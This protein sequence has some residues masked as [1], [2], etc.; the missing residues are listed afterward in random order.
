MTEAKLPDGWSIRSLGDLGQVKVGL[1]YKPENVAES[2]TLV[3]RSSNIQNDRLAFRDNVYV[4]IPIGEGATV[5]SGDL[6]ICVRNGS[7][8]L[9]GKTAMIEQRAE[10]MAFG[11]FM[12]AFRSDMNSYLIWLFQS[13]IIQAQIEENLGATINQIT[14]A[15]LKR[16]Q[17]PLPDDPKEQ[18]AIAET[19]SDA[20]ALIEGLERLIAKKR[21]I[22]KGAMQELLTAKRRLPRF[23][24]EWITEKLGNSASLVTKG[25]TPTS[26]GLAFIE[27]GVR[28]V[29]VESLLEN[30]RIDQSRTASISEFTHRVLKRSQLQAG[31]ILISIAGAIGRVGIV[32][33]RDLPANTNQALAIVRV[34]DSEKVDRSF[35]YFALASE[36]VQNHW[37][38]IS[39]QG[40]QPNISL[41]DVRSLE[42]Q[43][44]GL[45]E[46][47]AIA[48]LLTD[49]D[50]EIQAL[51]TRLEKARQVKEGIMQ[52]LLTGQ[53]RLV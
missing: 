51:E 41:L 15:T 53:V 3:L 30:G 20:D 12:S 31:D 46:Q 45:I 8:R 26:I 35:L 13:H 4:N 43:C 1:T 5:Q 29:K 38:E 32:G 25:T 42:F 27:S 17:I 2:G 37:A 9:I 33:E 21:L 11:A 50:S 7:R 34:K 19:L 16:F 23:S 18:E 52:H 28:F 22:K 48:A 14:N 10:G 39:V 6:L 44:P 36:A 24:G 49:M 47:K 40:A